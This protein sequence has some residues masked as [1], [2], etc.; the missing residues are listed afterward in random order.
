MGR[1]G[2]QRGSLVMLAVHSVV[3]V[4]CTYC[5]PCSHTALIL[6]LMLKLFASTERVVHTHSTSIRFVLKNTRVRGVSRHCSRGAVAPPA[7]PNH[8]PLRAG[9][10]SDHTRASTQRERPTKDAAS[11]RRRCI[12]RPP[13]RAR[14]ERVN[15]GGQGRPLGP[16]EVDSRWGRDGG[17]AVAANAPGTVRTGVDVDRGGMGGTEQAGR[18]LCRCQLR[19]GLEVKRLIRETTAFSRQRSTRDERTVRR[20]PPPVRCAGVRRAQSTVHGT[21]HG[22]IPE[23]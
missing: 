7:C 23:H 18:R 5:H 12:G 14:E 11:A 21:I 2:P 9:L 8:P 3:T 1:N 22:P 4:R 20:P 15:P 10:G 13:R 6:P 17:G 19:V 16:R